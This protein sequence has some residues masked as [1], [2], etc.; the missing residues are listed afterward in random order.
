MRW[1]TALLATILLVPLTLAAEPGSGSWLTRWWPFA[2]SA[3]K[4]PPQPQAPAGKIEKETPAAELPT[5][6]RARE[7]AECLRRV[8]VCDRLRAIAL[9]A[10]DNELLRKADQLENR[11]WEVYR[12][13]TA[14]LPAGDVAADQRLLDRHLGTDARLPTRK[15]EPASSSRSLGLNR[16]PMRE[17][18]P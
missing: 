16:R 10:N 11:A 6:V 7:T 15:L 14:H 17:V 5:V 4:K 1:M 3:P 8:A 13:R 9:Q 12:Q 2:K 18:Q